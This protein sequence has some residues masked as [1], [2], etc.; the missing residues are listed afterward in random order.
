VGFETAGF[1]GVAARLRGAAGFAFAVG[2]GCAAAAGGVVAA[3]FA[4]A[5]V[6]ALVFLIEATSLSPV[7][8]SVVMV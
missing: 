3:G 4:G 7:L 8:S 2:A 6:P 5:D 1:D